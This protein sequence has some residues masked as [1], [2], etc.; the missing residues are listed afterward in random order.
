MHR[1]KTFFACGSSAP[2][3]VEHEGG[4]AA[5]LAGTLAAPSVQDMDY[6]H[7]RSYGPI[8]VFFP[9]SCSWWSEGLFDQS[10]SVTLPIQELR[11]LPCLGSFSVVWCVRHIEGSPCVGSYSAVQCLR[12]LMG[13]SF[14]YSTADAGMWRERSYGDGSSPYAWLSTIALLL[15]LPSLPPRASPT[16]GISHHHLL[17]HI[18][19]I[20]LSTVNSSPCPGIALQSLNSSSQLLH[21]PGD[22]R[23]CPGYVWLR[24]GMSHSI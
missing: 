6:L 11:G 3:R 1:C 18:P 8:R 23:P 13:Q 2:V 5:W 9:A 10:F 4:I 14:Y 20:Q 22:L 21:L 19:L 24:Q 15:W 12:H 7:R 17:P 16:T